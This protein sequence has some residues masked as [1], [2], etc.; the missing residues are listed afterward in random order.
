M[1]F[2]DSPRV[3]YGR[4]PLAEVTCKIQFPP[5]LRI[6]SETPAAFQDA[7]RDEYPRYQEASAAPV[8]LPPNVPAEMRRFV[9][10]LGL[11]RSGPAQHQFS[12][13]DGKWSV[14][15]TRESLALRTTNYERWEQFRERFSRANE[16]LVQIYRPAAYVTRVG[17]RYVDVIC[18]SKLGLENEPWRRLLKPHIAGEFSAEEIADGIDSATRNVHVKLNDEDH[19]VTLKSGLVS[20]P[21]EQCFMIDSDFH[22]HKRT[23]STHV[24]RKL[25]SFNRMGG[26]LFRWCIDERL[27]QAL[28]PKPAA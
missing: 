22:T 16:A 11:P 24:L 6:D 12:S 28:G 2:P 7:I 25:D 15:L 1:P 19:Y 8:Q 21:G 18:R 5:V 10:G 4:N 17:L 13:E 3:V 9:Q 20:T 27:H 14:T 23:E 26:Q